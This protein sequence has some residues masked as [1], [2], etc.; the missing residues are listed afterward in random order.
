MSSYPADWERHERLRDGTRVFV[1][2]IKG[3]DETLYPA[4]MAAESS[5]DARRRFFGA[6]R[7]LSHDFIVRLTHVDYHVRMAF[8]AI[9][10]ADAKMLGVA[11]L[12]REEDDPG[13]AEYAVIVRSDF[14]GRG[15]GRLLMRRMIEWSKA[16]RIKTITGLVL[17][18][19]A[20]MLKLCE[21]LGFRV[22]DYMPDRDIK[23]VSLSLADR[24]G[25]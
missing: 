4:F 15:L 11:R 25:L 5:E 10:E 12:H 21:Q 18:D 1:R 22:S 3:E 23:R 2:P 17:A 14:K 20:G 8:I 19:N 24:S 16:A 13:T 6:V 7:D 9:D